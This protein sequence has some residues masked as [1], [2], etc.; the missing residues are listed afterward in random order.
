MKLSDY[1]IEFLVRE[2]VKHVFVGNGGNIV[3]LDDSLARN[4]NISYILNHHEQ[5]AAMAAD[6]Y[7]RVSGNLGVAMTTSGPG[8]T[9][10]L[11]GVCC[12]YFD[13]IPTLFLTGQVPTSQIKY[14]NCRARQ[15]GFQETDIVNTF[16]PNTKYADFVD[17]P[18]R[19]RFYLEKA[20]YLAKNGRPGPVLLDIPDDFQ[21]ADIT[22]NELDPYTPEKKQPD[23]DILAKKI[24][25]AVSLLEQAQRP[26]IIIGNGVKL[27]KTERQARELIEKIQFPVI[28]TWAAIDMLPHEYP[29]SVRSF[30]VT[31]NR[32]GN[33]TVQNADLILA[34]GTRL[35]THETGNDLKKFSRESK[36]IVVDIDES[37]LEKYEKRGLNV[38]I[39]INTDAKIFFDIIN[40]KEI[41]TRD[42]SSWLKRIKE[43]REK[44][45]ICPSEYFN[46]PK[47]INPYV[48]LDILSDEA[49]EGDIIIPEAGCNVTW[50]FQ[51]WKIK[52]NQKLI[53][54]F[55]H[56]PMGYGLPAAIGAS[57]ASGKKQVITILGDGGIMMNI[58]ELATISKQNL[59]IKIFIM[60]NDGYAM[61]KQ[62]QETWL[63]SRYTVSGKE[64][65]F[66]PDFS[67]TANCFG[68]EKTVVITNHS[69]LKEKIREVLDYPGP[70]LC[71]ARIHPDA[72]IYPKLTFGKPIE[73]SA[74]LLPRGEFLQNMIVKPFD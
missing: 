33:F 51:G 45:P 12:A 21:R 39:S 34:I 44:Y 27:S 68:I 49:K 8:A 61:I 41:K 56:S 47:Q 19:I 72:R 46:Q 11:T 13:S 4:E 3:H 23:M 2:G 59:P 40:K 14:K 58:H 17:N 65:L 67:R 66:F 64:S 74:P 32:P 35:D 1:V 15:I 36:K 24:N 60:N 25:E 62:T 71:D 5:A 38:D 6:A 63:D 52:Q 9:N 48:F 22:P 37:E 31:A 55:N 10:L 30:G 7:S 16:K 20:V 29:L 73:D 53:T 70:V 28:L 43:W 54:S 42:I 18:K 57:L 26:V 50:T 69:E